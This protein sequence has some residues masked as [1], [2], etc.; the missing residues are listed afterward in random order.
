MFSEVTMFIFVDD[1]TPLELHQECFINLYKDHY[2]VKPRFGTDEE[3]NS[4]D[5]LQEQI[6]AILTENN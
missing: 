1:L 4:L 3:W 5:W 6:N 2:G